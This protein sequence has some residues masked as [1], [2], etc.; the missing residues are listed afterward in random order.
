MPKLRP[1]I[2]VRSWRFVGL[3][4]VLLFALIGL[5]AGFFNSRAVVANGSTLSFESSA[6][7]IPEG[8]TRLITVT[9]TGAAILPLTATVIGTPGTADITDYI[10]PNTV[11]PAFLHK[12]DG[13]PRPILAQPDGKIVVGGYFTVTNGVTYT[14][15]ARF[16][17]DGSL[18]NTFIN[19]RVGGSE[20]ELVNIILLPNGK[21]LVVVKP[22]FYIDPTPRPRLFRLNS[23]GSID[24]TFT[25]I[26]QPSGFPVITDVVRQSDG[27][28]LVTGDINGKIAARLF[29]DGALD[30][31]FNAPTYKDTLFSV[32]SAAIQSD[33]KV[34]LGGANYSQYPDVIAN[35]IRLNADGSLET[36]FPKAV[37][38]EVYSVLVQ[39]DGKIVAAG[40][41]SRGDT[42]I[43]RHNPDGSV[44]TSFPKY[45]SVYIASLLAQFNGKLIAYFGLTSQQVGIVY[46][47]SDGTVDGF[48]R[49]NKNNSA[50]NF[51]AVGFQADGIVIAGI[52]FN[53]VYNSGNFVMPKT[54]L[55]RLNPKP[56]LSWAAGETGTKTFTVTVASDNFAE[57]DEQFE[58]GLQF[59]EGG[60]T[61]TSPAK[62]SV[63]IPGTGV[64][65]QIELVSTPNPSVYGSVVTFTATISPSAATGE[66]KFREGNVLL[67]TANLVN[68]SA[69]FTTTNL[70]VGSHVI[71]A[72]YSG[73]TNYP[74]GSSNSI[75]QQVSPPDNPFIVTK[76]TDDG[77]G[78][79]VGSLSHALKM[80]G[81]LQSSSI[82]TFALETG[83]TITFTGQLQHTVPISTIIDGGAT[84]I[85]L[86]GGGVAGDGLRLSG[87][88]ILRKLWVRNF[89]GR[90][91]VNDGKANKLDAVK[92][93]S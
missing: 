7:T 25:V 10:L 86:E 35:V 21:F 14:N 15:I 6:I 9:R 17:P 45:P 1:V 24:S 30:T 66:I 18:D 78:N 51:Y 76:T 53:P 26:T 49:Y 37:S 72:T 75:T 50:L 69:V 52:D 89:G 65:S 81:Q 60:V 8:Q 71:S 93:T 70:R 11:E 4:A 74:A 36:T 41:S 80:A 58:L 56:T 31:S 16:N 23:D 43:A 46:L 13:Y 84:Q 90:E 39:P 83:N 88:N 29:S 38:H 32:K 44:D 3:L 57:I 67:G 82:I 5:F 91:I 27:K 20:G 55:V 28:L 19:S 87:N 42:A 61:S 33:S 79:T 64:P 85:I 73:N 47:N 2:G 12:L 54:D 22:H 68:G 59:T 40:N 77:T 48:F 63:T 34:V 62:M 92:V